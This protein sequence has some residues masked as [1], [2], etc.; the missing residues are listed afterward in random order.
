MTRTIGSTYHL[1]IDRSKHDVPQIIPVPSAKGILCLDH[2]RTTP[3]NSRMDELEPGERIWIHEYECDGKGYC[4]P[5]KYTL[6]H[7]G[8]RPRN[9]VLW[10]CPAPCLERHIILKSESVEW[11][12]VDEIPSGAVD[13]LIPELP[14]NLEDFFKD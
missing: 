2:M 11:N 3:D 6:Y 14:D 10:Y 8:K 5:Q 12:V 4:A 1:T 13:T 7:T 9:D